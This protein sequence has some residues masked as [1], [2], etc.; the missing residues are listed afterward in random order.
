MKSRDGAVYLYPYGEPKRCLG[1]IEAILSVKALKDA[2]VYIG[3]LEVLGFF[4][5]CC[6]SGT[7]G[8]CC[9]CYRSCVCIAAERLSRT[10]GASGGVQ[11]RFEPK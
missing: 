7:S 1:S 8:P 9:F 5:C 11:N 6:C 4:G 2:L 3:I 10:R